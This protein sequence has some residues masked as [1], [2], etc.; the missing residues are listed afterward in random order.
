MNNQL[1]EPAGL[2]GDSVSEGYLTGNRRRNSQWDS[3]AFVL[4]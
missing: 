3:V 4:R 1:R 2:L